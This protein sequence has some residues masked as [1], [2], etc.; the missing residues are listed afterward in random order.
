[1]EPFWPLGL[2][3][4]AGL[5]I[6]SDVQSTWLCALGGRSMLAI[7][8]PLITV[9]SR[10]SDSLQTIFCFLGW[11]V[12]LGDGHIS[13]QW[14]IPAFH[15]SVSWIMSKDVQSVCVVFFQTTFSHLTFIALCHWQHYGIFHA[16][17]DLDA[18]YISSWNLQ[19]FRASGTAPCITGCL[20]ALEVFRESSKPCSL[21][22]IILS[23]RFHILF[24]WFHCCRKS[25]QSNDS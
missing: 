22:F 15:S 19:T 23:Q 13:W 7:S 21:S 4:T 8:Y 25:S 1:M 6:R 20:R 9:S 18:Y 14:G 5:N 2:S 12:P 10:S 16:R 11:N 24:S 17:P 3:S